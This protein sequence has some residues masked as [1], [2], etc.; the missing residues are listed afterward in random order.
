M[1]VPCELGDDDGYF[2]ASGFLRGASFFTCPKPAPRTSGAAFT[3]H[4]GVLVTVTGG[5]LVLELDWSGATTLRGRQVLV[6]LGN[7]RGYWR[8][9][10]ASDDNPL[11]V[12]LYIDRN[13]A[14]GNTSLWFAVDDGTGTGV[15]PHVGP[16]YEM[17]ITIIQVGSGDVQVSLSWDTLTDVDLH[18]IDPTGAEVYWGNLN[19]PSGGSQDLDSNA[20][21]SLDNVNNENIFWPTGT[22]PRGVYIVRIDYW[23][24]CG[25]TGT[26]TPTNY[27][28]TAAKGN[29]NYDFH[30]GVLLP[31]EM[32]RGGA[33]SGD[34][35]LRF[36]W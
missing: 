25:L 32:D 6:G 33:G 7:G 34:E 29:G 18:V 11:R 13:S 8:T 19:V 5:T 15:E 12:E 10:V 23:D 36:T 21:C 35:V 27:R 26:E 1:K 3:A 14:G 24:A 17:P 4:T 16:I 31:A 9:T 20:A 22:A 28:V 30:D 2:M